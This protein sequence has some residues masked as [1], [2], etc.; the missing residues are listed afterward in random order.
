MSQPAVTRCHLGWL[1]PV[2][3]NINIRFEFMQ[4]P[5]C[6]RNYDD[7]SSQGS[8]SVLQSAIMAIQ[9]PGKFRNSDATLLTPQ[10]PFPQ[11]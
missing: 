2:Q 1:L 4:Q 3:H 7:M 5:S 6:S 9:W 11:Y 10:Q 8:I